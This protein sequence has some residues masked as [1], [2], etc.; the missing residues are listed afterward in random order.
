MSLEERLMEEIRKW[1]AKLD[2]ALSETKPA[3]EQGAKMLSN[4]QAYRQDSKHFLESCDLI[5]SFECLIW[6]WALL[7]TGKEFKQLQNQTY[8]GVSK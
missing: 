7:E 3:G 1:T 8:S 6:A 2:G 5:R 4:I